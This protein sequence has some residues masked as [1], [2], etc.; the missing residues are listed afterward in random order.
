MYLGRETHLI[1]QLDNI[2]QVQV[3]ASTR[4]AKL[5]LYCADIRL[6]VYLPAAGQER[7][8]IGAVG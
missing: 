8:V 6:R 2:P 7:Q 3:F 4:M 5:L 1:L